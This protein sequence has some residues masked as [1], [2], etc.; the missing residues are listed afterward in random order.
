VFGSRDA[1]IR[2]EEMPMTLDRRERD[3]LVHAYAAAAGQLTAALAEA[4]PAARRWR[5][6][7]GGWSSEEVLCHLADAEA[8]DYV[9]IRFIA[10]EP[11][12]VLQSWSQERWAAALS[13]ADLP[14]DAALAVIQALRA[15]TA[16]LLPR[17]ADEVWDRTG[18][19]TELGPYT[20]E[21]WLRHAVEH[22]ELHVRQIRDNTAGWRAAGSPAMPG[23]GALRA[24]GNGP[25]AEL[26]ARY[27][28]GA[29]RLRAAWEATPPSARQWRPAPGEWSP[30]EVVCHTADSETNSYARIRYLVAEPEPVLE[31][32]DQERWARELDYHALSAAS[33]LAVTEAVRTHTASLARLLD[34]SAWARVGRHTESGR[35]TA[36]DWLH[37]YAN[38]LHDHAAQI[39]RAAAA[40]RQ[41]H[42]GQ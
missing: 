5:S 34:E 3:A 39:E 25:R 21:R 35:Y 37:I 27:T 4:P 1:R 33:A 15:H 42:R 22:A 26:V 10:A 40:W 14:A 6:A 28:E 2:P 8:N 24:L 31:G 20:G 19:H 32:Y 9:R 18:E 17:L 41:A 13:Y 23:A 12:P 7:P 11:K 16:P 29:A 30:H 36:E 38:H